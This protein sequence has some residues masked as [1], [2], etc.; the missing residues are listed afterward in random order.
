MLNI[1][2]PRKLC[3]RLSG[4]NLSERSCDALASVIGSQ[5]SRLRYVDLSN[6]NL[7]D[8]GL[9]L[10][11]TGLRSPHCKLKTLRSDAFL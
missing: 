5:S 2:L 7:Q 6:N 3:F 10:L 9:K 11:S 1:F 4:S 8:T